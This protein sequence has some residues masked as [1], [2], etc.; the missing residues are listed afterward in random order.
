MKGIQGMCFTTFLRGVEIEYMVYKT[1]P[2]T[3]TKDAFSPYLHVLSYYYPQLKETNE[4][5]ILNFLFLTSF[6]L[7]SFPSW[8]H[9]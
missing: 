8:N 6:F 3:T 5:H 1:E 2:H 4:T 7:F 9:L